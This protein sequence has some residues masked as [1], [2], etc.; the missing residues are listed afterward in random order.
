MSYS[1]EDPH[2]SDFF[3]TTAY[4]ITLSAQ[5][6][7]LTGAGFGVRAGRRGGAG[8]AMRG[9][10]GSRMAIIA[11]APNLDALAARSAG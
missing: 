10:A 11:A 6:A 8:F 7:H 5:T 1:A 3:M 4:D 9:A 2:W